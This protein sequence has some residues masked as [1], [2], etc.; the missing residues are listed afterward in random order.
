M[1]TL[2]D[3]EARQ[4]TE[5]W[6][7][8]GVIGYAG[9][10]V[11]LMFAGGLRITPDVLVVA[12]GL[13]A[14]LLGRT[15]LFLR[16][17]IPFVVIFLAYELMRGIADDAG[18]P[19]HVEDVAA[20]ELAIFGGTLPTAWLQERMAP[21]EGV[22]AAAIVATVLY[23]L[24]FALPVA[25]G[26]LLW[27]WRRP[28]Y[29]DYLAA[30]VLLSFAGF[31]TF[32][33]LPVAP[34]WLAAQWGVL[35]GTDGEPLLRY[36]KPDAFAAIAEFLGYPDGNELS[37][38]VFYGVNPNGVAAFPSLHAGYPFLSFLV[39]RQAFGRIGYL[40]LAYAAAVWWAIVFTGDHYVVDV[41]AGIAYAWAVY[42]VAPRIGGWI[43]RAIG[44]VRD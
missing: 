30:F 19:V 32:L 35:I 42:L 38:Y 28:R 37:S 6:L 33:L 1:A 20:I 24:H 3:S 36:L 9:L 39:L 23:M 34:P 5:R 22:G 14:V 27:V 17:W 26:F 16:D 10:V 40:A 8:T 12:L 41:V 31:V 13:V 25:T 29:H 2:S 15:R 44:R 4:R 11:A 7:I 21:A 18:F 43:G